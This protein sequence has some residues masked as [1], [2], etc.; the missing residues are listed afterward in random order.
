MGVEGTRSRVS[1]DC[2]TRLLVVQ[3]QPG[4][5]RGVVVP[6][7]ATGDA[8]AQTA[9][10]DEV[11]HGERPP[12]LRAEQKRNHSSERILFTASARKSTYKVPTDAPP[13]SSSE[14]WGPDCLVLERLGP[15]RFAF[16]ESI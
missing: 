6:G 5:V 16:G 7:S 15:S 10:G 14:A 2:I 11:N 3:A 8:A 12:W 1:F 13:M 4:A 9:R